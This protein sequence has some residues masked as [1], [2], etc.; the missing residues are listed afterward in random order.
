MLASGV[1]RVLGLVTIQGRLRGPA[2]LSM[3]SRRATYFCSKGALMIREEGGR[4]VI[5]SQYNV[6]QNL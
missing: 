2:C 3:L 4:E 5:L 1:R 6:L